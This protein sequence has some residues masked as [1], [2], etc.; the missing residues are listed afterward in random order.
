MHDAY[1]ACRDSDVGGVA[2]AVL[3]RKKQPQEIEA[4][5]TNRGK[6]AQAIS[7]GGKEKQGHIKRGPLRRNALAGE[8]KIAGDRIQEIEVLLAAIA[9]CAQAAKAKTAREHARRYH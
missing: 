3:R 8:H 4:G 6:I 7:K 2:R 5:T 9:A 1:V